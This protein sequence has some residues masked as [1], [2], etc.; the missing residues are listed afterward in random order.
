M[1]EMMVKNLGTNGQFGVW[2]IATDNP[3]SSGYT[4]I[5][6]EPEQVGDQVRRPLQLQSEPILGIEMP[7]P[8]PPARPAP[9]ESF[10][11]PGTAARYLHTT[12]RH[13][14][15]MVHGGLIVGHPLDPHAKKKDW[16]CLLSELHTYML[17]A[18]KRP[19]GA[20]KPPRRV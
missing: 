1:G 6:N 16:R 9:V 5:P 10:V 18:T 17:A 2:I 7:K 20:C 14:L 13:V 8:F 15:E 19:P 3:P 4:F 11:D 12:R